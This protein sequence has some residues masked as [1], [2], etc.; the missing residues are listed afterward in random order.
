MEGFGHIN[1][2]TSQSST[3]HCRG[4]LNHQLI[5]ANCKVKDLMAKRAEVYERLQQWL[6]YVIDHLVSCDKRCVC[7]FAQAVS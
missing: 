3:V 7:V 4:K 5:M 2:H 1:I 6:Q